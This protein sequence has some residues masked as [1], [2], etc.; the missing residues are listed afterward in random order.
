MINRIT[1]IYQL[2]CSVVILIILVDLDTNYFF[3]S[4]ICHFVYT[5]RR[6]RERHRKEH[7]PKYRKRNA[8]VERRKS[9][10]RGNK[11][12]HETLSLTV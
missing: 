8:L 7:V 5:E 2:T 3:L 12:K 11:A 6:E 10:E 9:V 1:N 4:G